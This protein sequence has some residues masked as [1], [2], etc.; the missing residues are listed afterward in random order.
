MIVYFPLALRAECRIRRF[1]DIAQ[2]GER[3]IRIVEVSGSIPL[4]SIGW[5][6]LTALDIFVKGRFHFMTSH[7]VPAAK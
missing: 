1:G 6:L 2:L 7:P 5:Y 4:I 3:Y